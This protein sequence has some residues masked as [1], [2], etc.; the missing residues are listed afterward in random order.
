M[1]NDDEFELRLGKI[2]TRSQTQ[3]PFARTVRQLV[4]R[5]GGVRSMRSSRFTGSRMGKGAGIGR[6]LTSRDRYSALRSRQVVIKA[7]LIRLA[8]AGL[9]GARAHLRYL[10][11]DGVTREGAPGDLYDAQH[12]EA[13][14][15][16]FLE[17]GVGDRHQFRFIL[18]AEDAIEYRDLKSLTRRLMQ[19]MEEDL[20]TRL[21]WVA[22]D[23]Y[24]TGHPHSHIVLRGKDERGKDLIIAREYLSH[25][26]RERAA[27]IVT[28]D[29]GPRTDDEI[30]SRLRSEMEQ[31][32]FTSLDRTLIREV[33][34][35]LVR[36]GQDKD[37][38]RQTLRAGRLQ[39]LKR[40]GLAEE[41]APSKWRLAPDLEPILRRMGERGDV[42]KTM[43]RE[44]A[45]AGVT[46]SHSDLLI[47]EPGS[48]DQRPL[49]G[50][51]LGRGLSDELK[52]RHYLII[53]SIDG[54]LHYTDIGN[55]DAVAKLPE[56]SIV[57][58]T[59][60]QPAIHKADRTVAEVA[61]AHEGRYSL[62]L[63]LQHDPTAS[64]EYAQAHIRRLEA[65]RRAGMA[66]ERHSEGTWT[67]PANHLEV[68]L[69]YE[70]Q[71]LS[72]APVEVEVL[73]TLPLAQQVHADG[74]TWL[75]R[76]LVANSP[77]VLRDCE[78][79][80]A[81]GTAMRQRQQWLLEQDLAEQ[82]PTGMVYRASL[83][84]T[85]RQRELQRVGAQLSQE[86]GM[87]Y[88]STMDGQRIQGI[89][90]RPIDL[91]SGRFALIQNAREFSLVPW[92]P[93]L[94]RNLG[95]TVTG[96]ARGE[97]IS[98]QFGRQRSGPSVS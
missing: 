12:D 85:L 50:K 65:M 32:R 39:K 70:Q 92:R 80:Q 58:V 49:V 62:D 16:H 98:W 27:E 61:S 82:R 93:V 2:R 8:K 44:M 33:R 54:R 18:S 91:V 52:D 69:R 87:P 41:I 17:R 31:E 55:G 53:D 72:A 97:T 45:R 66:I 96:I 36:S 86:F 20:G 57:S 79:G 5:A 47:Y 48:Q 9:N 14:G 71:R 83:I 43:H 38:F 30:R 6:V 75:D 64:A 19:Q 68:A 81:V 34:D 37:A 73:S 22:V 74:A 78:F 60:K 90:R 13:D 25:G 67:I 28:L 26:M 77:L 29:L 21:E 40:L 59:R 94:D 95:K 4:A 35:G 24:N 42:I 88:R 76:E 7:R 51:V 23:H 1:T 3:V 63:H 11:R 84:S 10:Q 15:K 56:G 89:Y 46:R